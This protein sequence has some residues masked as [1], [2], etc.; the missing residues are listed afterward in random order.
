M[1]KEQLLNALK[2]RLAGLPE[3]ELKRSLDFYSEMVDDRVEDGLSENE[4]VA[5]LGEVKEISDRILEDIPLKKIVS[6]KV[7]KIKPE[8]KLKGWEIALIAAGSPIWFPVGLALGITAA[9][10]ALTFYFVFWILIICFYVIDLCLVLGGICGVVMGIA[11]FAKGLGQYGFLLLGA[12]LF[13]AGVSIPFFF[14]CNII[15]KGMLKLSKSIIT[16]IKSLFVRNKRDAEPDRRNESKNEPGSKTAGDKEEEPAA[17][18]E[19]KTV[20]TGDNKE[21]PVI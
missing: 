19:D 16:G 17:K 15:A 3:E 9:V 6:E 2:E 13:C 11:A 20:T 4:A 8:R 18:I 7:K 14:L 10:L 5:G 1:N 12:G 21:Q